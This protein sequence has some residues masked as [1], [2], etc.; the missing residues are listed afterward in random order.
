MCARL[1]GF[2]A[3]NLNMHDLSRIQR[4]RRS[5][6]C[7]RNSG[8]L[9]ARVRLK[10]TKAKHLCNIQVPRL[11]L[12]LCMSGR[13]ALL[14]LDPWCLGCVTS[15]TFYAA[16]AAW[17]RVCCELFGADRSGGVWLL[18]WMLLPFFCLSLGLRAA[19]L[20]G[21]TMRMKCVVWYGCPLACGSSSP[22]F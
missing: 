1:C 15:L 10:P 19:S 20:A 16:S 12:F 8:W 7:R 9:G 4:L 5:T 21:A 14:C 2:G 13:R 22:A 6:K 17:I 11:I 3:L 18:L